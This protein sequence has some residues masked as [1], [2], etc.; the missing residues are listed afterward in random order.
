MFTFKNPSHRDKPNTSFP[1]NSMNE[2]SVCLKMYIIY[3]EDQE[4][5]IGLDWMQHVC[6]GRCTMSA[7]QKL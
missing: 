6:N 5:C 1:T 7:F 4:G 3:K 2:C